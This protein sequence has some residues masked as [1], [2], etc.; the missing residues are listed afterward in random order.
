MGKSLS[1]TTCCENITGC[2][3]RKKAKLM[4]R[5][6][7]DISSYRQ[8][9]GL[10][11]KDRLRTALWFTVIPLVTPGSE[12]LWSIEGY[13]ETIGEEC[14]KINLEQVF[15][16]ETIFRKSLACLGALGSGLELLFA[17]QMLFRSKSSHA[18]G[19]SSCWQFWPLLIQ[20]CSVSTTD[21][22]ILTPYHTLILQRECWKSSQA[23]TLVD[24]IPERK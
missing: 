20:V 17:S 6:C 10:S 19:H 21:P 5:K 16:S 9:C 11:Y 12:M 14:F 8:T 13:R 2:E 4:L 15:I 18:T 1:S 23:T 22:S 24:F 3:K 7:K